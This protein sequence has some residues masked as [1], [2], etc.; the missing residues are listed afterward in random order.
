MSDGLLLAW[1]DH[2]A[3]LYACRR[4]HYSGTLPCGK[5]VRVGVW[6][7]GRFIGAVVFARGAN[8]CIGGPFG[9][10]QSECCELVRVALTEHDAPVSRIVAIAVRMLRRQSPGLRAIVSYADP[11]HGH[12]GGIYQ[13]MG[14]VYTGTLKPRAPGMSVSGRRM[15]KRTVSLRYG[16]CSVS[17]LASRGVSAF[18][19][20]KSVKYRYI[21]PLDKTMA[22]HLRIM[23]QDYPKRAGGAD[24]GTP[25][26]QAGGGG[27]IPTPALR[28]DHHG[29]KRQRQRQ[30]P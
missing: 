1:C 8:R 9:L 24:S 12:H 14:W 17:V 29:R 4:W 30:R 25:V 21:L 28:E 7:H 6:E 15:H 22:D 23:S 10:S 3:A 13:A 18:Y 5:Q 19:L 26:N 16:T 2:A 20:Q 11:D 27:A